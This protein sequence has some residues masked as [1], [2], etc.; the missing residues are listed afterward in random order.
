MSPINISEII[1]EERR[2]IE[3]FKMRFKHEI[4]VQ[5]ILK[6]TLPKFTFRAIRHYNSFVA[7]RSLLSH[8]EG[9][10][11]GWTSIITIFDL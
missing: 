1:N 10:P 3:G 6:K 2:N 11:C 9:E 4:I 7:S 8:D 5:F